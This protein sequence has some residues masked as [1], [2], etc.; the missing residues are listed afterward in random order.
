MVPT[1]K[2][3]HYATADDLPSEIS[4]DNWSKLSSLCRRYMGDEDA[5]K[6]ERAYWL[7]AEK[8]SDRE[9]AAASC[10]STIP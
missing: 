10:I 9:S 8:H 4:A 3:V 2:M 5:A 6:A 7:A 1:E